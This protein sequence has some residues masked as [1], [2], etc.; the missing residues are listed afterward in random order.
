LALKPLALL[1][2]PLSQREAP[3]VFIDRRL[4]KI[5]SELD[6][7]EHS[8]IDPEHVAAART[9]F[10]QLW[11]VLYPQ[12]KTRIVHLLVERVVYKSNQGGS[13]FVFHS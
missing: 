2:D 5:N 3:T 13:Q 12:E 6:A 8:T 4:G 10:S 7:I 1:T 11:D 9:E